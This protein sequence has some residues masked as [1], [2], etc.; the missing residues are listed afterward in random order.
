MEYLLVFDPDLCVGCRTCEAICSLHHTGTINPAR[1]LRRV[2]AFPGGIF[3]PMGCLQ[4]EDPLCMKVCPVNAITK[5]EK[6][7][8]VITDPDKCIGCKLCMMICPFGGT[9]MDPVSKVAVRCDLC[10]G[11]P[12]CVKFCPTGALEYVRA[13]TYGMIKKR[14]S[15]EKIS[16][17]MSVI[18]GGR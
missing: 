18:V 6:T 8:A 4:C 16:K 11:D 15:V 1:S 12:Q 7:G 14:R 9:T 17:V 2:I 10:D 13:D 3:V 5:D